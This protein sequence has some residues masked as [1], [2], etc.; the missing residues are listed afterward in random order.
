MAA[1][2]TRAREMLKK[3]LTAAKAGRSSE[4]SRVLL[5]STAATTGVNSYRHQFLNAMRRIDAARRTTGSTYGQFKVDALYFRDSDFFRYR[6]NLDGAVIIMELPGSDQPQLFIASRTTIRRRYQALRRSPWRKHSL[7]AVYDP[8]RA[9]GGRKLSFWRIRPSATR[10]RYGEPSS[11]HDGDG[12]C[13]AWTSKWRVPQSSSARTDS[14]AR[15]PLRHALGEL[16]L[17]IVSLW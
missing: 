1:A 3:A 4:A 2:S 10:A 6:S 5:E 13:S 8:L 17:R 11:G 16:A 9:R 15:L 14:I 7:S 12:S